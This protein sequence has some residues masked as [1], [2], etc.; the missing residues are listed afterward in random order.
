MGKW[1][2]KR[3]ELITK[4]D[5]GMKLVKNSTVNYAETRV[6]IG[7]VKLYRRGNFTIGRTNQMETKTDYLPVSYDGNYTVNVILDTNYDELNQNIYFILL[8]NYHYDTGSGEIVVSYGGDIY[9]YYKNY[10]YSPGEVLGEVTAEE[11]TLPDNNRHTDGYW[12][13]KDRLANSAPVISGDEAQLGILSQ[14]RDIK[15]SVSDKDNDLVTVEILIDGVKTANSPF[16]V[17]LG[18]EYKIGLKL[19][20]YAIGNHT[21][22]V[23]ATDV[24]GGK[25]S[26]SWYFTRANANPTISGVDEDLG[27][28]NSGFQ[29]PFSVDDIDPT[30]KLTVRT[31]LNNTLLRTFDNV[32]RNQEYI[33]EIT[34]GQVFAL[35]IGEINM[36]TIT[37]DDNAGGETFRY[38]SFKRTNTAPMIDG[39]DKSLGSVTKPPTISFS[40]TDNEN[41]AL[42]YSI[43]LN[44]IKLVDEESLT[45]GETV[46]Y[47]MPK[48]QFMQLDNMNEHKLKVVVTDTQKATALRHFT[49]KRELTSCWH[50]TLRKVNARASAF[51]AYVN[52]SLYEGAR[53]VVTVC[54]NALDANPKW[55]DATEEFKRGEVHDFVNMDKTAASWAIGMK[56]E[57]LPLQ[58]KGPSWINGY[59]GGYK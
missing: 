45:P 46:N 12:Y 49:F 24:K 27:D 8:S 13:V 51:Y 56:V 53:L 29:I 26:R 11:G 52:F 35:A 25:T 28:R 36:I 41:D 4:V 6:A 58:S 48:K 59:G 54:N 10:N 19:I 44:D 18:R 37:V 16:N 15:F 21:V 55:E 32:K 38:K 31:F 9:K 1:I 14:D 30:D 43:L 42:T 34:D 20:D 40:A 50:R 2:Y 33:V 39:E 17:T 5:Q 7:P 23:K 47:T 22:V 57:I 3:R